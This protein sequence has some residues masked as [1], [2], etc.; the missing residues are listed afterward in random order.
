MTERLRITIPELRREF[1]ALIAQLQTPGMN[2]AELREQYRS[3]LRSITQIENT[4]GAAILE[5]KM[6]H[7]FRE[8]VRYQA[9]RLVQTEI[10]KAHSEAR[11][12]QQRRSPRVHFLA[13]TLSPDHPAP[14]ICDYLAGVDKYG[15]GAGVYP[16]LKA[17]M[18]PAHP[19]CRCS[20]VPVELPVGTRSRLRRNADT[21]YFGTEFALDPRTASRIAGS[22]DK[23]AR[24]FSGD[25]P[26]D[27]LN[28]RRPDEYQLINVGDL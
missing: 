25:D 23:L 20:L 11:A 18:P 28:E 2:V 6:R 13:W 8:R 5:G 26:I 22:R 7:A 10:H 9:K 15:L 1:E 3:V 4:Q 14:D 27:I 16:K 17:P 21:E 24:I 19:F 12:K